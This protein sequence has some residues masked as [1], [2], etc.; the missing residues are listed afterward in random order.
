MT[1]EITW[2]VPQGSVLGPL[3][4]LISINDLL[5]SFKIL[6]FFLFLDD[7]NIYFQ[8]DDLKRLTKKVNKEL[9]KV[10]SWLGAFSKYGKRNFVLFSFPQEGN[11][12]T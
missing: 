11:E 4:F 5:N 10:K 1:S 9:N 2:A 6:T 12:K 8:S 3:Q 7:A